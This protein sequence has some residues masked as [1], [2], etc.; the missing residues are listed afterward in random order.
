MELMT[1]TKFLSYLMIA[2]AF[3]SLNAQASQG[4]SVSVS[5]VGVGDHSS[6]DISNVPSTATLSGVSLTNISASSNAKWG[7]GGGA[8]L[9]AMFD[10]AVGLE[11]GALYIT[12]KIETT[13]TFTALG[14]NASS[15]G[16]TAAHYVQIPILLRLAFSPYFSIGAGGYFAEG[17]GSLSGSAKSDY[18][19]IG[20]VG[21]HLPLGGSVA[22]LV[23]GRY[24]LGLKNV[25]NSG[26]GETQKFRDVQVLAGLTFGFDEKH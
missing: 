11:F 6:L 4:S 7:F 18:G 2:A 23:D 12:R 17:T 22:F 21:I 26:L 25:D 5:L 24:N 20:S 1:K 3:F 13:T 9:D 19:L 8:L 15:G 10:P 14:V 16:T